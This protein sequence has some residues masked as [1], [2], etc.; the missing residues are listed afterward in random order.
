MDYELVRSSQTKDKSITGCEWCFPNAVCLWKGR[1]CNTMWWKKMNGC[2]I[3][4][5]MLKHFI[6]FNNMGRFK[7]YILLHTLILS[8]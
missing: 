6:T 2:S 7:N 5:H 8:R 3:T 4:I 1:N